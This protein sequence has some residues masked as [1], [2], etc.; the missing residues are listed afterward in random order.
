M[1]NEVKHLG[2]ALHRRTE[3]EFLRLRLQND[4]PSFSEA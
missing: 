3:P 1:L 4:T 2:S